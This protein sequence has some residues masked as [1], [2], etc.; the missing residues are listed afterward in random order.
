MAIGNPP[1]ARE[2]DSFVS[3]Q[4]KWYATKIENTHTQLRHLASSPAPNIIYHVN[5]RQVVMINTVTRSRAIVAELPFEP[6]CIATGHGYFVAGNEK[7]LLAYSH[8]PHSEY[9][10]D[11]Q[12]SVDYAAVA[13]HG[14]TAFL[15]PCVYQI[16]TEIVNSITLH[17]VKASCER[18][19]DEVVAMITNNDRR[20][21]MFC[22]GSGKETLI[23][24]FE[25]P[26]NHATI[27]PDGQRLVIVGDDDVIRFYKRVDTDVKTADENEIL[28]IIE[29]GWFRWIENKALRIPSGPQ[30]DSLAFFTTAWNDSGSLC[31][32]ASEGGYITVLDVNHVDDAEDSMDCIIAFVPSSRPQSAAGAVRSMTF[33]PAPWDFLIWAENNGRV[34]IADV[35][36]QLVTRQTIKIDPNGKNVTQIPM[37]EK[38]GRNSS[39]FYLGSDFVYRPW[40]DAPPEQSGAPQ[41]DLDEV[42]RSLYREA[43]HQ[44]NQGTSGSVGNDPTGT[45]PYDSTQGLEQRER[46]II[47]NLRTARSGE[48]GRRPRN[49]SFLDPSSDRQ[50]PRHV[51]QQQ[52]PTAVDPSAVDN[53]DFPGLESTMALARQRKYY[54]CRT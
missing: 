17:K 31:A 29:D 28:Q 16:G 53:A 47:Q 25:Q 54:E 20:V 42:Q 35:R 1:P 5:N 40:N 33:A 41:T 7:G 22:L 36:S 18:L 46:D 19:S 32:T 4:Q 49:E 10:L 43:F 12:R 15:R 30:L 52:T 11:Y 24:E 3:P 37:V 23:G 9:P 44:N 48:S 51:P 21:K 34:C 50:R 13:I 2:T 39:R 14:A 27:S 6:R 45:I 8:I 26:M 38:E